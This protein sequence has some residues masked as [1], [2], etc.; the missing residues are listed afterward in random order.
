[1]RIALA[2]SWLALSVACSQTDA[3]DGAAVQDSP[4]TREAAFARAESAI[5]RNCESADAAIES[6]CLSRLRERSAQCLA[7]APPTLSENQYHALLRPYI[8][9]MLPRPVCRGVELTDATV[10]CGPQ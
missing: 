6:A 1:M 3:V 2:L 10:S 8:D 9:C 7:E 5:L 4:A